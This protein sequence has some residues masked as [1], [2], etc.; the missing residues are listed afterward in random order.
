L[1]HGQIFETE[2]KKRML[3]EAGKA[4]SRK[5]KG[6]PEVEVAAVHTLDS[7]SDEEDNSGGRGTG[8]T[9]TVSD[10]SDSR[11]GIEPV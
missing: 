11:V 7:D 3:K 9:S 1:I 4:T 5:R 10:L 2:F 8:A 6:V